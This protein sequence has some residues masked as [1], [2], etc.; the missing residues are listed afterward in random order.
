MLTSWNHNPPQYYAASYWY[1]NRWIDVNQPEGTWEYR[2]I[3]QGD[4]VRQNFEVSSNC[5]ILTPSPK[6]QSSPPTLKIYPSPASTQITIQ[7]LENFGD[8]KRLRILD[9]TGKAIREYQHLPSNGNIITMDTSFLHQGIYFV[10]INTKTHN[11]S[12][13]ISIKK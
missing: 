5:A 8:I 3:L 11:Y 9:I 2:V 7:A 12:S 1:W 13:K 6:I 10:Q 4:T